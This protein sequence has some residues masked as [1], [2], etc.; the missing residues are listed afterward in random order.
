MERGRGRQGHHRG[1]WTSDEHRAFRERLP[2]PLGRDRTDRVHGR[3]NR[4]R[5]SFRGSR[6][7]RLKFKK[8]QFP[9]EAQLLFAVFSPPPPPPPPPPPQIRFV[10]I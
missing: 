2:A 8:S 10:F 5:K 9:L 3:W 4:H 7:V 6:C 1:I